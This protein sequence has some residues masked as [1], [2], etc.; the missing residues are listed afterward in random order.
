MLL[1]EVFGVGK[2]QMCCAIQDLGG[3]LAV[4]EELI[5]SGYVNGQNL[6]L[7]QALRGP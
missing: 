5:Y 2:P 6:R 3:A 7:P 1:N 4:K